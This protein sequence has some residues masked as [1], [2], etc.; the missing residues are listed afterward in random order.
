[1]HRSTILFIA[2]RYIL[3]KSIDQFGRYIYWVSSVAIMIGVM[4]MITVLSVMNGFEREFKQNLLNFIPHALLTTP[5]GYVHVKDE[6]NS[7]LDQLHN[8]IRN[9]PLVVSNVILQSAKKIS[10]GVMLGIDPNFFEPL[11][12]YLVNKHENQ[13]I[14]G[15]YYVIIGSTLAKQLKVRI[16]DQ[17]R[18]IIPSVMQKT[19]IGYI[20]SQRLF[21]V[22]DI[23]IT[24]SAVDSYQVLVHQSDASALMH[25]P[26]ECVTGWRLWLHEPCLLANY[27]QK[28]RLYKDWVWKDWREYQGSLF[29]AMKIEKN[30]MSLLLSLIIIAAG[31]NIVSFLVLLILEKRT[32]IAILKTYGFTRR[33]IVFIFMI[34][35]IT[36][37]FF[38]I[39]LGTVS[40]VLLSH[41]LNQILLFFKILPNTIFLPIEIKYSQ[42]LSIMFIT[43]SIIL[44][45]TLYPSW[46]AASFHPAKILRYD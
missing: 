6:P 38:G 17:V 19:P 28:V 42:I 40:G 4:A 13:L 2:I 15:K 24:N 25:Y 26:S 44:L 29:Q 5:K 12:N 31:F 36:N 1:M 35:G 37:G 46:R 23:Y 20:P 8:I 16:N 11:C 21:T 9:Q 34:Q 43:F 33:Q 39:V 41:K 3:G 14:L 30:V 45:A 18:L 7:V 32:D 22:L 10:F 27:I